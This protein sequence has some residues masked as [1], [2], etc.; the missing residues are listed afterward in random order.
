[1]ADVA[2]PSVEVAS[3]T[4]PSYSPPPSVAPPT[5]DAVDVEKTKKRHKKKDKKKRNKKSDDDEDVDEE[6][7]HYSKPR[8]QK[9]VRHAEIVKSASF[10]KGSAPSELVIEI[11]SD[12]DSTMIQQTILDSLQHSAPE[13]P[14]PAPS[15]A[16][17]PED[18][19]QT[20]VSAVLPVP[21]A[22]VTTTTPAAL[23]PP[24]PGALLDYHVVM[25]TFKND[26][27][28]HPYQH[29]TIQ[30]VE[31]VQFIRPGSRSGEVLQFVIELSNMYYKDVVRRC[32][33]DAYDVRQFIEWL[34]ANFRPGGLGPNQV[35]VHVHTLLIP[36]DLPGQ[37]AKYGL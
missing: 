30:C 27:I 11:E 10:K 16:P 5:E 21:A 9:R 33:D 2:M 25:S 36:E 15:V 19:V 34:Y 37:W 24:S 6:D 20:E 17:L 22:A 29:A 8:K 28:H 31:L 13:V 23:S 3:I 32:L 4:S 35:A 18:D 26:R 12:N 14:A 1:M 7:H